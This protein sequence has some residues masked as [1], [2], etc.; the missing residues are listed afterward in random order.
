ML[1]LKQDYVHLFLTSVS[2]GLVVLVNQMET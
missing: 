2:E 1:I